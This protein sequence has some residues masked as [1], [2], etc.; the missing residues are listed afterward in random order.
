M[1]DRWLVTEGDREI[2]PLEWTSNGKR[3]S[4]KWAERALGYVARLWQMSRDSISIRLLHGMT[5][6]DM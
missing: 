5:K 1:I 6:D 4:T 2:V 3:T